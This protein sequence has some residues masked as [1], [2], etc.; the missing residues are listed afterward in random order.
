[1][2]DE[3]GLFRRAH[4]DL[5]L[6]VLFDRT[7]SMRERDRF[8]AA[9]KAVGAALSRLSPSDRYRLLTFP[10]TG[11]PSARQD[12]TNGWR[13]AQQDG[14]DG[15]LTEKQLLPS[16]VREADLYRVL[17]AE[18]R[19]LPDGN[20]DEQHAVLL[21]TDGDYRKGEPPQTGALRKLAGELG[22]RQ[23]PLLVVSM[24]PYGCAAGR[25][26]GVLAGG[27]SGTCTPLTGALEAE[28]SRH[29]AAL[30]EGRRNG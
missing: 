19:Q 27:A 7:G 9:D 4:P 11:D 1:M 16:R 5:R 21:V 22:R 20:G 25:D 18:T 15:V 23:V 2:D 13:T 17:S 3:L 8:T 28:L 6:T 24:R 30:T 12:R 10:S 26:T 29:V 14:T